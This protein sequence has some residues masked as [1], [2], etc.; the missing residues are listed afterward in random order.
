MKNSKIANIN[1]DLK[2][3]M[4]H[5]LKFTKPFHSLNKQQQNILALLLYYYFEYKKEIKNEDMLWKI[6]FDYDTKMKIKKE[7]D[8]LPDYTLQNNLTSLRKKKVIINN[9]VS[10]AYIPNIE[11]GAKKF[12]IQ[13]NFNIVNND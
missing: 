11:I 1:T 5:W 13:Y 2:T 4:K 9:T 12:V 6:V 8:D 10:K 3:L 7:L